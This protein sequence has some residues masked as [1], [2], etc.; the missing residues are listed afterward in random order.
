MRLHK[1]LIALALLSVT[2]SARADSF[3]YTVTTTGTLAPEFNGTSSFTEPSLLTS[4]TTISTG[5]TTTVVNLKD[6]LINPTVAS[7]SALGSGSGSCLREDLTNG[8]FF[9]VSN[10]SLV[11]NA[12]G[13]YPLSPFPAFAVTLTIADIPSTVP[14]PSSLLLLGSG[15]LGL[16]VAGRRRLF[17]HSH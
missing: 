16:L 8:A 17:A 14:E 3:L 1:F 13:T 4:L 11:L 6:I 5:I 12:P 2:F 10:S 15:T 9:S 7:C